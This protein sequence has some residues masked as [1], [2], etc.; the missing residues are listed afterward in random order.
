MMQ[1]PDPPTFDVESE[2]RTQTTEAYL[3]SDRIVA[4]AIDWVSQ[5]G[6]EHPAVV[7][8]CLDAYVDSSRFDDVIDDIMDGEESL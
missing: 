7:D 2:A 5:W 6:H 8:A 3:R 4:D 1:L